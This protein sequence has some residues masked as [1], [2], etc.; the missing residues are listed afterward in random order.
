M[1]ERAYSHTKGSS[2]NMDKKFLLAYSSVIHMIE[3]GMQV[4]L[5]DRTS[6]YVFMLTITTL[7][8]D[9]ADAPL[10]LLDFLTF[11]HCTKGTSC[12]QKSCP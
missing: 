12:Y 6:S 1:D 4:E 11:C 2:T 5:A 7:E 9:W 10:V 3:A 8:K